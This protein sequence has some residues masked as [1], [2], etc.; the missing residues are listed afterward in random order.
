[1]ARIMRWGPGIAAGAALMYFLDPERGR[2]RRVRTKDQAFAIARRSA[3]K[4]QQRIDTAREYGR[5]R[6][7][8]MAHE[9]R[10]PHGVAPDND[11]TLVDKI[12]SEVLGG[13]HYS[14][15][16]IN[17]DAN[18]GVVT[19]RGQLQHPDEIRKLRDTVAAIPGVREVQSFLH[20][21]DTP[22]P[23]VQESL[24]AR[25]TQ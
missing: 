7:R 11:R 1:M 14:G 4:A 20:L 15:K 10:H 2:T 16:T 5:D 24:H 17:V 19:L 25:G 23:N 6:A 12:R 9:M 3:R 13:P 18:E 22:A 21:P 8:G